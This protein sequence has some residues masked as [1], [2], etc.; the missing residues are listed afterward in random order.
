MIIGCNK[1]TDLDLYENDPAISFYSG[2]SATASDT[3]QYNFVLEPVTRTIDTIYIPIRIQGFAAD[4][5]RVVNVAAADSSTAKAGVHYKFGPAIVHAGSY[6]DS[7]P[8]Y[9]Y[10]TADMV[11]STFIVYAVL[12][13]SDDFKQGYENHLTY[14]IRITDRVVPPVWSYTMSSTFGA[15]SNV[16]FRF[17]VSVLQVTTFSGLLPSQAAAMATRCKLALAEYEA[18]NGNLIDE[19]GQRVVFP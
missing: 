16:K 4:K 3:A 18:A 12:Q 8:V 17:M 1:N 9:L 19:N 13:S 15:F 10:R 6:L 7:I 5:D 11:D 2:F 14:K